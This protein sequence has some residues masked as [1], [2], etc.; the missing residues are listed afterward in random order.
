MGNNEL[1]SSSDVGIRSAVER[2]FERSGR[3]FLRSLCYNA[4][5]GIQNIRTQN[6][7]GEWS[8]YMTYLHL[9][10]QSSTPH[11]TIPDY[12]PSTCLH[13]ITFGTAALAHRK[14]NLPYLPASWNAVRSSL[15][16]PMPSSRT[17]QLHSSQS[18]PMS[19]WHA[20]ASKAFCTS[21][22]MI[23]E[24]EVRICVERSFDCVGAGSRVSE[25]MGIYY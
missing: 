23:C 4:H 20:W 24:R 1:T 12:T 3:R 22:E 8:A 5:E 11:P 15:L 16:I 6:T 19:I 2:K 7:N 17:Q 9:G 13:H 10:S 21:S 14:C 25:A 18:T